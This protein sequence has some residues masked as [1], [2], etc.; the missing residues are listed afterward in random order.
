[1]PFV[2]PRRPA[3]AAPPQQ[4]RRSRRCPATFSV[5]ARAPRSCPPPRS[6]RSAMCDPAVRARARPRPADRRACGRKGRRGRRRSLPGR[7]R[8]CRRPAPRRNAATRPRH[9]EVGGRANGL[10]D[11]GLVVGGLQA[12]RS[13]RSPRFAQSSTRRRRRRGRRPRSAEPGFARWRRL[14]S[15]RRPARKGARWRWSAAGPDGRLPRR[16]HDAGRQREDIGLGAAAGEHHVAGVSTRPARPTASRACSTR[17]R[18]ARPSACTEDGLP[19]ASSA[20][21]HGVAGLR[22]KRPKSRCGRERCGRRRTCDPGSA[23][24]SEKRPLASAQGATRS[25]SLHSTPALVLKAAL[26]RWRGP[27]GRPGADLST[28]LE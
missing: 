1:M 12:T 27:A 23:W 19:P 8:S 16:E 26:P 4:R 25:K 7:N 9:G 2:T 5:P 13:T 3:S 20:R 18:A 22:P 24:L 11:A 17:P 14:G 6:T 28:L 10:D 15:G 21:D